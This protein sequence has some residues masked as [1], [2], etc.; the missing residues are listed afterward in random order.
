MPKVEL[1]YTEEGV[2]MAKELKPQAESIGGSLD[3][4]TYD[5]ANRSQSVEGYAYGGDVMPTY[6]A[7]KKIV[8]I[9]YEKTAYERSQAAKEASKKRSKSDRKPIGYNIALKRHKAGK[10]VHN[11]KLLALI[12][13]EEAKEA[14]TRAEELDKKKKE[15]KVVT[16]DVKKDVK[17]DA[18]KD[19]KKVVV[20]VDKKVEDVDKKPEY[21]TPKKL[22][23]KYEESFKTPKKD[24]P[25]LTP[26]EVTEKYSPESRAGELDYWKTKK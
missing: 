3:F 18:K 15:T 11:K 21:S 20:K 14:K 1:P 22:K 25:Y 17:K 7:G 2:K 13:S 26:K 9:P 8:S 16:K 12:K 6:K 10:T 5:A 19:V 4:D 24:R 23:K